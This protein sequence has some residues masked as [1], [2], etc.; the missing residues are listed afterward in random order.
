MP[1]AGGHRHHRGHGRQKRVSG[2]EAARRY[3][4]TALRKA[5]S[6]VNAPRRT[7]SGNAEP[8]FAL[9][10]RANGPKAVLDRT[11]PETAV[12]V[13]AQAEVRAALEVARKAPPRIV[14]PVAIVRL[15]SACQIHPLIAQT[16]SGRLKTPI[17]LAANMGYRPGWVHFAARSSSDIDLPAFLASV[18]PP[19]ADEQYGKGH[20]SASGGAL[21]ADDWNIFIRTLGFGR[22]MDAEP[23]SPAAMKTG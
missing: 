7:A 9:L 2:L 10:S 5:V 6:L 21:R 3:G 4:I 22:E 1:L 16:W 11:F 18:R 12:L 15:S 8:A 13:A 20:R 23:V 14:G 17:V 19:G